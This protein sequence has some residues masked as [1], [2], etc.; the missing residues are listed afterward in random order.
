MMMMMSIS[1]FSHKAVG[2]LSRVSEM[3][4]H[5]QHSPL[6]GAFWRSTS[7]SHMSRYRSGP[8]CIAAIGPIRALSGVSVTFTLPSSRRSNVAVKVVADDSRERKFPESR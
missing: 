1:P 4:S 7:L 2:D 6:V 5:Q 8:C 3:Y